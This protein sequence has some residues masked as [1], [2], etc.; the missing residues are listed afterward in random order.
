VPRFISLP[1]VAVLVLCLPGCGETKVTVDG[2][3]TRGGKPFTPKKEEYLAVNITNESGTA[4]FNGKVTPEGT[5]VIESM[6]GKVP[7]GKYKVTLS[8]YIT[9]AAAEKGR[10]PAPVTLDPKETWEVTTTNTSF[11]IDMD[12]AGYDKLEKSDKADAKKK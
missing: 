1:L 11:T 12:K 2:K 3:L 8:R 4:S 5:F 9:P 10:V 6:D 7:V